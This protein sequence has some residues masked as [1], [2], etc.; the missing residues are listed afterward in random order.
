MVFLFRLNPDYTGRTTDEVD[1][2]K[3]Q[4]TFEWG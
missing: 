2:E 4:L 1:E 3:I